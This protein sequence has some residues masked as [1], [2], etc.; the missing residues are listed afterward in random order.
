[1]VTCIKWFLSYYKAATVAIQLDGKHIKSTPNL[2][3]KG[4]CWRIW[5]YWWVSRNRHCINTEMWG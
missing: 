5:L 3:F 1:M 4:D 2:L